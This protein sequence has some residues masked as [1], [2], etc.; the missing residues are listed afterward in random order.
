LL[1]PGEPLAIQALELGASS[2]HHQRLVDRAADEPTAGQRAA[3]G[4]G[5]D[6]KVGKLR[7]KVIVARFRP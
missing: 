3:E 5:K 7:H 2:A 1:D 4:F 6:A